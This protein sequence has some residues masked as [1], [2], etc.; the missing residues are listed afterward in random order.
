MGRA[1]A[2]YINLQSAHS[3]V[4]FVYIQADNW[5]IEILSPEQSANRVIKKILF[6]LQQ[7]TELVW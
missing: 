4:D 1:I 2:S 6:V 5:L 3:R 7:G